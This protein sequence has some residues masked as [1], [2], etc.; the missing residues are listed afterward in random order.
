MARQLVVTGRIMGTL[1]TAACR[2]MGKQAV[3]VAVGYTTGKQM[4]AA[5]V[6]SP[7]SP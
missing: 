2:I 3:A 6:Q 5:G 1:S 7:T 4:A